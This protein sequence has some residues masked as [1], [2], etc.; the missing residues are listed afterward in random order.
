MSSTSSPTGEGRGYP[1]SCSWCGTAFVAVR[2]HAR[3]CSDRCRLRAWR[4]RNSPETRQ[5]ERIDVA[6]LV[7]RVH[8]LQA[9]LEREQAK[10]ICA[11][12]GCRFEPVIAAGVARRQSEYDAQM[13]PWRDPAWEHPTV[14]ALRA[15]LS[16]QAHELDR[17]RQENGLLRCWVSRH[18][19]P[20][21]PGQAGA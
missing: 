2:G 5:G 6:A 20:E 21:A 8:T 15:R 1:R 12:N 16:E 17:L 10:D 18:V 11:H 9:A 19:E 3:W 14:R 13:A 4:E 7:R